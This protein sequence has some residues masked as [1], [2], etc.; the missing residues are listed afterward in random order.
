MGPG[1]FRFGSGW[2][3][4]GLVAAIRVD[5]QLSQEFAGSGVDDPDVQVLD[6]LQGR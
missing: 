5:D 4:G 1:C 2:S 6:Q 3:P